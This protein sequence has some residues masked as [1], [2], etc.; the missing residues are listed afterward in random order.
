[1]NVPVVND[2]LDEADETFT[3]VLS[4]PSNA[5]LGDGSGAAKIIDFDDPP[6]MS[7]GDVTVTEGTGPGTT[8]A[9]FTVTLSAASGQAV[10]AAYAT[11]NGT[12]T[13]PADY[14]QTTGTVSFS[15]GQTTRTISV[16]VTR[17]SFD[18]VNENFSVT[19]SSPVNATLTPINATG[20]ATIN[21]D[22]EL[23]APLTVS[24]ADT[25]AI[26]QLDPDAVFTVSLSEPSS[27][28]VTVHYATTDG[29]AAQ[30]GDY[31]ETSGTLTF[32][33]GQ[34]TKTVTVPVAD[35]ALDEPAETFSLDLDSP[36]GA[37]IA[38]DGSALATVADD[39]L[40][41]GISVGDATV[42]RAP[43]ARSPPS[44]RSR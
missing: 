34:T 44:S 36:T 42:T 12:A 14:T 19:L 40:P 10:S 38:G 7:I 27:G 9:V 20:D 39:D 11:S 18:E 5:V 21:D 8:N 1:M 23:S 32:T 28:P 33:P 25:S 13:Q 17:D 24:V 2:A 37:T 22:D 43:P 16:P 26:E 3:L 4:G 29:T 6:S 35:D 41:P 15:A 31:A 30:P